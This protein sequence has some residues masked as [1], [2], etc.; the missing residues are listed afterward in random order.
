MVVKLSELNEL[1]KDKEKRKKAHEGLE[2]L[3]QMIAQ[4]QDKERRLFERYGAD[5]VQ[6]LE[7]MLFQAKKQI[8][9][10]DDEF[11]P[12]G[13]FVKV[14]VFGKTA[15]CRKFRIYSFSPEDTHLAY[16]DNVP[17]RYFGKGEP[18][19]EFT[20][21]DFWKYLELAPS[22]AQG[23]FCMLCEL[24]AK[25]AEKL[26][27]KEARDEIIRS[28]LE[29]AVNILWKIFPFVL[30]AGLMALTVFVACYS[31]AGFVLG[32][33]VGGVCFLPVLL[34]IVFLSE[35]R[36]YEYESAFRFYKTY[37][38]PESSEEHS[39]AYLLSELEQRQ[40]DVNIGEYTEELKESVEAA[41][42]Q[43][44]V[45]MLQKPMDERK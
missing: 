2:A 36:D 31:G 34:I 42:E 28:I 1:R 11:I 4:A 35:W 24:L 8:P 21:E 33:I 9:V 25:P 19:A 39:L 7:K 14:E 37:D 27:R 38:T 16:Y 18:K 44:T 3:R 20:I 15:A 6:G 17:T 29:I 10:S 22:E 5:D 30:Y 13:G 45:D 12:K 32:A 26:N 40:I 43:A 41:H 23:Y